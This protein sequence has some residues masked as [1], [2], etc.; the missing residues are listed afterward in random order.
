MDHLADSVART[1][2]DGRS[3]FSLLAMTAVFDRHPRVMVVTDPSSLILDVNARLTGLTGH[4][5]EEVI[6]A[7]SVF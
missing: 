1:I 5:P 7:T 6:G 3:A 4:A 2:T